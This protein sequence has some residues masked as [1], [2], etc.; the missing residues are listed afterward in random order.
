MSMAWKVD[1]MLRSLKATNAELDRTIQS[2]R[3]QECGGD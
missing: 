1:E 2:I 3:E